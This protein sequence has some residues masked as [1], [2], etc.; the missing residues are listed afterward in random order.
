[1]TTYHNWDLM[2]NPPPEF[3]DE[4]G[5]AMLAAREVCEIVGSYSERQKAEAMAEAMYPVMYEYGLIYDVPSAS[6]CIIDGVE[7]VARKV[8]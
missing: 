7:Y 5:A 3:H 4:A 1:M 2:R 8:L 6:V